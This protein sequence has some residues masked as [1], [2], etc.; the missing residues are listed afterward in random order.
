MKKALRT[1]STDAIAMLVLAAIAVLVGGYILAHQR[2]YL[3]GWVPFVGTDFYTLNAEMQTAQ[4]ITPGQGQVVAMAGVPVGEI[5]SVSLKNGRAVVTMKI[6]SQYAKDIHRN[7]TI[8]TRPKTGLNDMLLQLDPGT[9]AKAPDGYTIPVSQTL[10][11]VN[12]DEVLASL[13]SGTRNY[14]K[15]LIGGAGDGLKGN[16]QNLS[17]VLK[18]FNPTARDLDKITELLSQRHVY[19]ERSIHNLKLISEALA[20]KDQELTAWVASSNKVFSDFA[21]QDANLRTALS[22]LPTALNAT[23]QAVI[24]ANTLGQ[25]L[26]PTLNALQPFAQNLAP[27]SEASQNFFK[28]TTPVIQKQ[29]RPFA[30]Q[31]QP[32]L[33]VLQPLAS[34]LKATSPKLTTTFQILNYLLNELAY[35]QKGSNESYLFYLA[36]LNHLSPTIFAQQDALGPVHHALFLGDC[37]TL[38]TI[39]PGGIANQQGPLALLTRF[40]NAP[41]VV[42]TVPYVGL[43]QCNPDGTGASSRVASSATKRKTA[44]RSTPSARTTTTTATTTTS[45][46][47][48]TTATTTVPA[49]TNT[50]SSA[51]AQ[52][53][54]SAPTAGGER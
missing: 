18:R 34:N 41:T 23:N 7:A 50:T 25:K 49:T 1:Y 30:V 24:S 27:A 2:V 17:A 52:T 35:N 42:R 20:G 51:S 38:N 32:V 13:D 33:K 6:E 14:L 43:P 31:V 36:W 10:P 26:G 8:L 5:S 4:A 16:R 22:E 47:P 28:A 54:Q 19:V 11:N 21:A 3:P 46:T 53:L 39:G 45:S 48:T 40:T 9:G 44:A 37:S 12:P 29:L 15:L